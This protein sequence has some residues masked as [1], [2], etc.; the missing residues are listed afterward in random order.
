MARPKGMSLV[1]SAFSIA[2]CKRLG[3]YLRQDMIAT[4]E[5]DTAID[6]RLVR[7]DVKALAL[8]GRDGLLDVAAQPGVEHGVG[9]HVVRATPGFERLGRAIRRE[10]GRV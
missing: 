8:L 5:I 4:D 9:G 1:S 3:T 10:Q 2:G 7:P 6:D